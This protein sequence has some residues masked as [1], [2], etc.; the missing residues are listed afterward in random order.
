MLPAAE[1]TDQ[2]MRYLE[3]LD[4]TK[5]QARLANAELRRLREGYEG[6]LPSAP[7]SSKEDKEQGE[8]KKLTFMAAQVGA[9]ESLIK[10]LYAQEAKLGMDDFLLTPSEQELQKRQRFYWEACQLLAVMERSFSGVL[11]VDD[12]DFM[13]IFDDFK[14]VMQEHKQLMEGVIASG[15]VMG[16][17]LGSGAHGLL[18]PHAILR[19]GLHRLLNA[20]F[21]KL[22]AVAVGTSGGM[23]TGIVLA[24]ALT[25][26]IMLAQTLTHKSETDEQ[27]D[28]AAMRRELEA[29][30]ESL[31]SRDIK[32]G[33][34][35][36][37]A[38]I[39]QQCFWKP[40]EPALQGHSCP[41]CL[42]G[43]PADGGNAP[44]RPTRAPGCSGLHL[45][46]KKC[47]QDWL[48][49]SGDITCVY[50]RQ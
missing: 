8:L 47:Q 33:A 29:S 18:W 27:D 13:P 23:I 38:D 41:I 49:K 40:L 25:G 39:F 50:C 6:G 22:G 24:G 12:S 30:M 35:A 28:A 42:E 7:R 45:V 1:E 11:Q 46:H 10:M 31:R 4:A 44:E 14:E 37:L 16:G 5:Q 2:R 48:R 3:Q 36:D 43:F 15:A 21:G 9:A 19:L 26:I 17:L 32:P 34:I 20:T